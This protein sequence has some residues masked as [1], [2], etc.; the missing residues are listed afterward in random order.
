MSG[1][2]KDESLIPPGI[3]CYRLFDTGETFPRSLCCPYWSLR[4]DKPTQDNGYCSFLD[5]GD[6]EGTGIDLLWDQ[7]KECSINGGIGDMHDTEDTDDSAAEKRWLERMLE[8]GAVPGRLAEA[9][10]RK[11]S[12]L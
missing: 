6:W 8:V 2:S 1:P 12:S 9:V 11:L 5:K 4:K 10:Q 7:V 3:Y